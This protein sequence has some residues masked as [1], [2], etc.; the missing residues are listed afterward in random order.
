MYI[1]QEFIKTDNVERREYQIN[2][3]N[4][5]IKDN[6]LVVLPTGL[7]KT[8][9]AL[10]LVAKQLKKENN[11][12]LFLAPTKNNH[13]QEYPFLCLWLHHSVY[14]AP[15]DILVALPLLLHRV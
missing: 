1:N 10:F 8:I 13:H 15:L 12:I 5:A 3:A 9:I 2:I 7:G 14:K 11:K 4:S 6:T